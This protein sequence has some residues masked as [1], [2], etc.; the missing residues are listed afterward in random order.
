VLHAAEDDRTRAHFEAEQLAV[1]EAAFASGNTPLLR[2]PVLAAD[3]H[4]VRSLSNVAA[5][6]FPV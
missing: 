5:I 6:L 4:D 3:V 1:L 2:V